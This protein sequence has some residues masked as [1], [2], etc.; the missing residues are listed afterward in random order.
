[1]GQQSPKIVNVY[2]KIISQELSLNEGF[3]KLDSAILANVDLGNKKNLASLWNQKGNIYT[4]TSDFNSGYKCYKKSL[5]LYEELEDDV[6]VG[7]CYIN[8]ARLSDNSEK[9]LFYYNKALRYFNNAKNNLGASKVYNNIGV[10][11]EESEQLDSA[12]HYFNIAL[13]MALQDDLPKTRAA[14]LTNIGSVELK[15]KNL[16]ESLVYFD[17]AE[18]LFVK[19]QAWDGYIYNCGKKGEVFLALGQR[20]NALKYLVK[21]YENARNIGLKAQ[22]LEAV[23]SLKSFYEEE[24]DFKEALKF[25]NEGLELRSLLDNVTKLEYVDVLSYELSV[26]EKERQ[27][28]LVTYQKRIQRIRM[29]AIGI[30]VVSIF[31]VIA[32]ILYKMK[33][34][35]KRKSLIVKQKEALI[36][37]NNEKHEQELHFKNREL[38]QLSNYILQK[39][40]FI[41]ILK[42]E[43]ALIQKMNLDRDAM[44]HVNSVLDILNY[45]LNL[46]KDNEMLQLNMEEMQKYFLVQLKDKFPKLTNGDV[47]LLSL[48]ALNMSSK[49]IA[50]IMG[51][52]VESVHTKRYRLRKKLNLSSD[53]NFQEFLNDVT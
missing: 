3:Y 21:Q 34:N 10:V 22:Q 13:D 17:S 26:Q 52:S 53:I 20:D 29:M 30:L 48:L 25:A 24:N 43:I 36:K 15:R 51:I 7:N 8:F 39:R 47:K 42:K 11:Y 6:G 45:Q 12:I 16:E 18:V 32:L 50:P 33:S 37:A 14:C 38:R 5:E 9:Q 23:L 40:D 35:I 2:Q 27:L 46:S 44:K 31:I 49:D 19:I 4:K 1:M 41:D 28:E